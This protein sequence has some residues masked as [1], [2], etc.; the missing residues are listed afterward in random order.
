MADLKL[1][2]KFRIDGESEWRVRGA[3]RISVD[4][5]RLT[6]VRHNARAFETIPLSRITAVSIRTV[7]RL[8]PVTLAV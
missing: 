6:L 8:H 4:R 5:G 3:D 7:S 2:L 1:I